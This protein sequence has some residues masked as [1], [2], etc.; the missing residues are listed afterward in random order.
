MPAAAGPADFRFAGA[1]LAVLD[2]NVVLDWLVFQDPRAAKLV[3]T[4]QI[5]RLR[6]AATEDMRAELA[7]VLVRGFGPYWRVE[8]EKVWQAWARYCLLVEAPPG[9]AHAVR[10]QDASD[11]MFVDLA[12]G[13]GA[14]WLVSRD[15]AVLALAQRL[16]SVAITVVTPE[17]WAE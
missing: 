15:R 14:R 17:R 12:V 16:K 10:C 3:S 4:I 8:P 13:A 9:T 1:P 7:A 6:W 2:T 11:Q 5:G